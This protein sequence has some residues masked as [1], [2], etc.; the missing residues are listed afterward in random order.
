MYIVTA[1]K[2]KYDDIGLE[3]VGIFDDSDKAYEAK[4]MVENWMKEN[5]FEDY[6]VFVNNAFD[7]NQ[8]RWYE[9]EKQL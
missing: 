3:I 7:L 8:I 2:D 6:E 9:I 4:E 5:E 1:I